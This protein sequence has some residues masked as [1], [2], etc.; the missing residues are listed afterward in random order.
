[1]FEQELRSESNE[2]RFVFKIGL[3]KEC[4]ECELAIR[5]RCIGNAQ[6]NRHPADTTGHSEPRGYLSAPA[7]F[8]QDNE[9][10]APELAAGM[11]DSPSPVETRESRRSRY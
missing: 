2:R 9:I 1:M 11:T 6:P 7:A 8:G 4:Q 5:L 10:D 3:R